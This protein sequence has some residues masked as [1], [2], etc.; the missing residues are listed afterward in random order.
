MS[1]IQPQKSETHRIQLSVGGH[2]IHFPGDYTT[3]IEDVTTSKILFNSLYNPKYKT[4]MRR[5]LQIIIEK[6]NRSILIYENDT[7]NNPRQ[8]NQTIYTTTLG[9]PRICVYENSKSHIW[10][11]PNR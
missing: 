6:P 10:T 8:N 11:A 3:P 1:E 2:I 5:H 9:K 4:H 7:E